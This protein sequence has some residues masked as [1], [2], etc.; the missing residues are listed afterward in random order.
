MGSGKTTIGKKLSSKLEIP[1]IDSDLEI[2][3]HYGKSI[4]EIFEKFG[5]SKFREIESEFI[6]SLSSSGD[7]VLA[8]GGGMPC[9]STNMELLNKIGTTFYL[10]R[11][12]KEL[13]S[14]LVNAKVKRPLLEG[15]TEN[16][17]LEFVEDKLDVRDE[18]YSRATIILDREEQ[19]VKNIIDL[20]THLHQ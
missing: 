18:Y 2:E 9:F 8:T 16:E 5:E 19:T 14:R 12:A 15:L 4:G 13:T 6:N 20:A 17:L 7:F 3:K 1:F 11:S 10:N